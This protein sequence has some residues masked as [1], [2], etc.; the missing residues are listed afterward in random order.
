[1]STKTP[2]KEAG[3][4]FDS[5]VLYIRLSTHHCTPSIPG[6]AMRR[7]FPLL[8]LLA[9]VGFFTTTGFQCGSAEVTSA[10]LYM[11]QSQWD[12]AEQSLLK[13]LAK[14]SNNEEAWFL[15]GQTR[16]EMKKYNGMNEAY[17]KALEINKTHASEIGRNRLAI[18]AKL[19][20]DGVAAYNAGKED[21]AKYDEAIEDFDTAI[22]LCP[23]SAGTYY[24][25]ALTHYA[26][27][28]NA[29][30]KDHL[31]MSL[32]RNPSDGISANFLGQ[33][34][35]MEGLEKK[36][37]KDSVGALALFQQAAEAFEVAYKADP[38]DMENIT[39]LIDAYERADQSDK[40]MALTKEAVESDPE[41]KIF[42][43]AYGVFLLQQEDFEGSIA[44][45]EKAVQLDPEYDDATYN[46]G[47][48]YLN[49]GV[50]LKQDADKK[51]EEAAA[52]GK[53]IKEDRTYQEQFRAAIPYLEKAAEARQDDA[54]LWQQLGKV[55]ANLNMV[56]KSLAAFEKYDKITQ[57][58]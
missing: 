43:Y 22:S 25:A 54:T 3:V 9:I 21:P 1:M 2:D 37:A 49:W 45:F 27:E 46:L 5:D 51:A 34:Y 56:E 8:V 26:M 14:N 39:N 12:K 33:L 42:R 31:K 36:A 44:Q 23:D 28:N 30:A 11:Q 10:K 38:E 57:G 20:N 58:K 41:N 29:A 4:A 17:T 32:E 18:W 7:M 24:V 40:A 6:V 13:E 48:A 15:L 35:Y 55:Y 16:L 47:V 52:A 53:E 19:Y 50:K